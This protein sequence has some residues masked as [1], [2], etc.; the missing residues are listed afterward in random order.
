MRQ[1]AI[2][3]NIL[4]IEFKLF[5]KFTVREFVYM[6][7]GIGFGGIFLYFF[8][9]G[10]IPAIIAFPIFLFSSGLGLFLGLVDVNDQKADVY[11]RNY[12]WAITHP[13]QR[14]WKNEMIDSKLGQLKPNLDITQG[15]KDRDVN[16]NQEAEIIGGNTDQ[17][18]T[19]FIEQS[20]IDDI[21]REEAQRLEEIT[22]KA[23]QAGM[24][25]NSSVSQLQTINQ[26][27]VNQADINNTSQSVPQPVQQQ[28][29]PNQSVLQTQPTQQAPVPASLQQVQNTTQQNP[30][31]IQPQVQTSQP[32]TIK[33]DMNNVESYTIDLIK[34]PPYQGNLNFKVVK[35]DNTPIP[36]ALLVIK[37]SQ[38][39]VVSALQSD[40]NGE[41]I[42]NK[43]YPLTTYNLQFQAN[44]YTFPNYVL[45]LD[46][47]DIKPIK[48]VSN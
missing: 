40:I 37:D 12:I 39:R 2:P 1:H 8:S 28:Q 6:A 38:G 46:W 7:V 17:A 22:Q 25:T 11:F 31:T 14:V 20:K 4:D 34:Q 30:T 41:V 9:R 43:I 15:T 26:Q 29:I 45:V 18:K 24:H 47:N 5:T 19:Q 33:I 48:I 21:E 32:L 10:T 13:T 35:K 23:Q 42:S 16:Q 44:G 3:Q 36:Q 27:P